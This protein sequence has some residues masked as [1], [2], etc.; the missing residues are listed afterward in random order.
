MQ[1][2]IHRLSCEFYAKADSTASYRVLKAAYCE[3]APEKCEINR[4]Y[5]AGLPVPANLLP[6]GTTEI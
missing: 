2:C 6:D 3:L 4:R 1:I 5:L